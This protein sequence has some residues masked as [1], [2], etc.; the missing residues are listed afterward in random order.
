MK[1]FLS[2]AVFCLLSMVV[3]AQSLWLQSTKCY[4]GTKEIWQENYKW[5]DPLYSKINIEIRKHSVL[6]LAENSFIVHTKFLIEETEDYSSF[7]GV[8][9]EGDQCVIK[10]GSMGNSSEG[11][12]C[13]EYANVAFYYVVKRL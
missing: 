13:F 7:S 2:I 12:I 1:K 8:D 11:Y 9:D 4:V 3:T 5:S 10:L 6:V